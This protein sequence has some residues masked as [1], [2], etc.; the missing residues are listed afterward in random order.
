M[1]FAYTNFCTTSTTNCNSWS[2]V[3]TWGACSTTTDTSAFG[4]FNNTCVNT[5]QL[6]GGATSNGNYYFT[7]PV[8][9]HIAVSSSYNYCWDS[10]KK[11]VNEQIKE[12]LRKRIASDVIVNCKPLGH[13]EDM[14]E[15]RARET[16]RNVIG[17]DKF[18]DFAR[19]GSISVRAKSGLVYQIFPGSGFTKVYNNGKM[20][21]RLCVVLTGGFPP[22]DSLIM[23]YLLILN[24]EQQFNSLAIKHGLTKPVV[25]E[26]PDQ[27]PL[28]EI[29][30]SLKKVA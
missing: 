11:T 25:V 20:M 7:G 17:E 24:N 16:L 22:T 28:V 12:I 4:P 2:E 3:S 30:K 6:V 21:D 14:R 10:Q 23:R 29:F 8:L 15:I 1:S 27:R 9:Q 5:W 18:R 19:R 26:K 13:A